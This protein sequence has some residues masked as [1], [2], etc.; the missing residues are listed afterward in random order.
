MSSLV[1]AE[2]QLSIVVLPVP[3][4]PTSCKCVAASLCDPKGVNTFGE[5]SID[6]RYKLLFPLC[7]YLWSKVRGESKEK[8][9]VCDPMPELIITSSYV[10]SRA[11]SNT[12]TMGNPLPGSTLSPS[13][14][15]IKALLKREGKRPL[16]YVVFVVPIIWSGFFLRDTIWLR[17]RAAQ[18]HASPT[19][20]ILVASYET[21]DS[22][23]T[24][25]QL[26]TINSRQKRGSKYNHRQRLTTI[27][28]TWQPIPDRQ[29]KLSPNDTTNNKYQKPTTYTQQPTQGFRKYIRIYGTLGWKHSPRPPSH[30]PP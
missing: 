3:N 5:G 20:I 18:T 6:P 17:T 8:H 15:W 14:L 10:H 11:D 28:N 23:T 26:Q 12:F 30:N 27:K 2:K 1:G 19:L 22:Q 25:N 13:G 9:S 29:Q 4:I 24:N 7:Y 21:T 16:W